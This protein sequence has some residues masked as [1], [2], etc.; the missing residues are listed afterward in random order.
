M[1]SHSTDSANPHWTCICDHSIDDHTQD[2]HD[3]TPCRI[4]GPDDC[5]D[6]CSESDADEISDVI[7]EWALADGE[8][9]ATTVHEYRAHRLSRKAQADG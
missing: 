6:F 7:Y 3:D 2:E 1:T 4:C 8:H 9:W 5:P